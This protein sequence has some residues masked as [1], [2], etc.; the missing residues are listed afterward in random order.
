MQ[1][2]S[3]PLLLLTEVQLAMESFL[4]IVVPL[5]AE[6]SLQGLLGLKHPDV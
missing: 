2:V 5:A 6:S 4:D 1:E 3:A